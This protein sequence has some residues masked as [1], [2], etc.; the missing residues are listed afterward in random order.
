[1]T[2]IGVVVGNPKPKS[3]TLAA[4][5]AVSDALAENLRIS[6]DTTVVDLADYA[7]LLLDFK[8]TAARELATRVAA[9]KILV[10]ASPTYKASYT[11]LLKAFLDWYPNNGLAGVVAIPVMTGGAPLHAL[12]LELHLSPL[13]VELGALVP[14]RGLFL[15]EAQLDG[16]SPIVGDWARSAAPAVAAVVAALS[17][18]RAQ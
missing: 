7:G 12:A 10:V 11:G 14:V 9:H 2:S 13:L 1:V 18:N 17:P 5:M 3:R 15:I 6:P 16:L 4:A 8:S